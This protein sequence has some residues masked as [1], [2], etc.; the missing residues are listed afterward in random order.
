MQ[1]VLHVLLLSRLPTEATDSFLIK[2]NCKQKELSSVGSKSN[3][4]KLNNS[5]EL[6]YSG[7]GGG[8]G[9]MFF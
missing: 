7:G 6:S 4:A 9:E 5:E 2:I 1:R 3:R 8:G